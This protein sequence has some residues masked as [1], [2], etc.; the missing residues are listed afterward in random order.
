[1]FH[2]KKCVH[3][4]GFTSKCLNCGKIY[5]TYNLPFKPFLSVQFDNIKYI[6][7][8]QLYTFLT[9]KA[10]K[11]EQVALKD[12]YKKAMYWDFPGGPVVKTPCF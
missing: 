12:S 7:T 3:P 4:S 5:I 6:H 8:E 11:N 1:M 9:T 2:N 10:Y